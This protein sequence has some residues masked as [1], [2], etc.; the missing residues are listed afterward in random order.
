MNAYEIALQIA[1]A[2][3]NVFGAEKA[4]PPPP[5]SFTA[6][7]PAPSSRRNRASVNVHYWEGKRTSQIQAVMSAFDP[8]QTS[9]VQCK[10]RI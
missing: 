5:K 8:K 1:E 9:R 7:A 6:D 3:E 2:L 10:S 4:P